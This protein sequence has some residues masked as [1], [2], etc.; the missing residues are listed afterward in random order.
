MRKIHKLGKWVSHELYEDSIGR[1]FNSC[2]QLLAKQHKKNLLWKIVTGDEKRTMY[3]HP[4][5]KHSWVYPGQPTT[6]TPKPNTHAKKVLL[7][8]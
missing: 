3:D 2:I 4:R 1:R 7:C 5:R 8:I 6:A